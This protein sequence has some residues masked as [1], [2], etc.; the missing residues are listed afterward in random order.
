MIEMMIEQRKAGW[1]F[2]VIRNRELIA[3]VEAKPVG[4]TAVLHNRI[5]V[6]T[7]GLRPVYEKMFKDIRGYLKHHEMKLCMPVSDKYTPKIGKFWKLMG[8]EVFGNHEGINYAVM[9]C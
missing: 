7:K 6:Y 4:D 9:E 1:H 3:E 8:F 5:Y 2:S